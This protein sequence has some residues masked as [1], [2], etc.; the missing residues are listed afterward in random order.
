MIVI[1]TCKNKDQIINAGARVMT[2]LNVIFSNTQ[3]TLT[4]QSKILKGDL[5]G[6]HT[7]ARY[8]CCPC[9]LQV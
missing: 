5:V 3:G 2:I 4:L 8:C 6:I 1:V 9:Y 7:H